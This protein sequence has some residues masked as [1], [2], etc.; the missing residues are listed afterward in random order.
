[1]AYTTSTLV[2][3]ELPDTTPASLTSAKITAYIASA[4]ADVDA[5]VGDRYSLSYNSNANKFPATGDSPATPQVIQDAATYLAAAR[6][7]KEIGQETQDAAGKTP[8][9]L[10]RKKGLD[11]LETI[12]EGTINVILSDGTNLRGRNPGLSISTL[13]YDRNF[14][15]GDYTDGSLVSTYSGTLD[16]F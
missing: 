16:G 3:Y 10:M 12:R 1:M 9:E 4:T 8:D 2:G 15:T 6:C 5:Y 7:L 11:I 14:T 13:N